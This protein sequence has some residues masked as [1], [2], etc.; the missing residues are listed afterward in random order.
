MAFIDSYIVPVLTARK[1]EYIRIARDAAEVWKDLGAL[2]VMEAEARDAPVG[3]V[4]S[5]PRSVALTGEET[6][7]ISYVTF[8]DKAHRDEVMSR[9]ETDPRFEEM[10]RGAPVDGRRMIWGGFEVVVAA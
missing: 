4:T 7:F 6:V 1:D 9:M 2:S 3:E 5:F 8:R 10:M